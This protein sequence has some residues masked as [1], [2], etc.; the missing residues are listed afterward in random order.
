MRKQHTNDIYSR[1]GDDPNL[2]RNLKS[3]VVLAAMPM[4]A[5]AANREGSIT[6]S[7]DRW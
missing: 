1:F 5:A 7:E 6:R 2:K 4:I 3:T